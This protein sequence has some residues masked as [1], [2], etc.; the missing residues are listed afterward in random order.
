VPVTHQESQF[1]VVDVTD[2][3][4]EALALD[5]ERKFV[6]IQNIGNNTI[7]YRFGGTAVPITGGFKLYA[8]DV[9]II[10]KHAVT[11]PLSV[12]CETGKTSIL[13]IQET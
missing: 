9:L 4:S 3:A 7:W 12:V 2:Q 6:M 11:K 10:D 13:A 5:T 1:T 8:G